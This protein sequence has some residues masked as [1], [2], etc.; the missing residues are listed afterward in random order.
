MITP[1]SAVLYAKPLDEVAFLV[2]AAAQGKDD[3]SRADAL[4]RALAQLR[5]TDNRRRS[6]LSGGSARP[7]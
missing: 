1:G 2:D 3:W 4:V 7:T 5:A 6:L